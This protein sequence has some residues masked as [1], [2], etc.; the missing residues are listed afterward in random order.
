[1]LMDGSLAHKIHRRAKKAFVLRLRKIHTSIHNP[2]LQ[3][4]DLIDSSNFLPTGW[5]VK[6]AYLTEVAAIMA[7]HSQ[8]FIEQQQEVTTEAIGDYY[9]LSRNRFNRWMRDLD[10]LERGVAIQDALHLVGLIAGRPATRGIAEQILINEMVTR[11]WTLLLLARD[12]RN[13]IDRIRP[14]ARNIHMG[15]LAVRHKALGVVL[16]DDRLSPIDLLAIDKLRKCTERWTDLLC[17]S[18]MG[19]YDLWDLAFDKERA[20]EFLRDRTDQA[21]LSHRSRGW[22]LLLAGLRHSFQEEEGLSATVHND[23]RRLVRLMLNCFPQD[24][25]EM[26]FWMVAKVPEAKQC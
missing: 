10:D 16:S 20:E 5:N 11:V 8:I 2:A 15:H 4:P 23:D 24:A 17:C 18:I 25:P 22:V 3:L 19:Q 26:T 9:I 12:A 1:M 14:V 6:L 13:G 21:G 7:A